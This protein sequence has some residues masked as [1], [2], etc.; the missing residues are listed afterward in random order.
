M[1]GNAWTVSDTTRTYQLSEI[2]YLMPLRSHMVIAW[3]YR[4]G[5]NQLWGVWWTCRRWRTMKTRS[6]VRKGKIVLYVRP[7]W[8]LG[9]VTLCRCLSTEISAVNCIIPLHLQFCWN[10]VAVVEETAQHTF[11]DG[12]MCH[13]TETNNR[14]PK[15]FLKN[16]IWYLFKRLSYTSSPI[17]FPP[18]HFINAYHVTSS[19]TN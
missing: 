7:R 9:S 11:P 15:W 18:L 6:M 2:L 4:M 14:G 12:T 13:P 17:P 8:K 19:E 16:V 3:R 1:V 10:I 5:S